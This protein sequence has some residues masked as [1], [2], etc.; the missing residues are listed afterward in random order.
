MLCRSYVSHRPQH[1]LVNPFLLFALFLSFFK[2]IVDFMA[3]GSV[4][5]PT[6]LSKSYHLE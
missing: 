4:F 1:E 3:S 2:E 5:N 6:S